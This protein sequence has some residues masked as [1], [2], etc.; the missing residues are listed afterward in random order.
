[1]H[2]KSVL[3]HGSPDSTRKGHNACS[4]S[5]DSKSSMC[6]PCIGHSTFSVCL[7]KLVR[8]LNCRE[9]PVLV[10][11]L[12]NVGSK[13]YADSICIHTFKICLEKWSHFQTF[14]KFHQT[15]WIISSCLHLSRCFDCGESSRYFHSFPGIDGSNFSCLFCACCFWQIMLLIT[16]NVLHPKLTCTNWMYLW[17]CLGFSSDYGCLPLSNVSEPALNRLHPICL[18]LLWS[19]SWAQQQKH[20]KAFS[21]LLQ[22]SAREST[23]NRL[24][25][26]L[27]K[28]SIIWNLI[29]WQFKHH[30]LSNYT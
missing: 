11:Y 12:N 3:H 21:E 19:S 20:S 10:M 29:N 7:K 24:V 9:L 4:N 18:L 8:M 13:I 27:F 6:S 5:I 14:H 25:L 26:Q 1:M 2:I 15:F 30:P 23:E 28:S 16:T 22:S 17:T